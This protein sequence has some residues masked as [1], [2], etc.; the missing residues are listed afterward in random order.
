ME[1]TGEI[2]T[3]RRTD[4][5]T[6]SERIDAFLTEQKLTKK[7]VLRLRLTMEELLLRVREHSGEETACTLQMGRRIG[8]AYV[9]VDYR[10][11]AFDP[12]AEDDG[13]S[14]SA[15]LLTNMGLAPSW[16]YVRGVNRL[17]LRPP[18]RKSRSLL[19]LLCAIGLACV[20]GLAGRLLPE[21]WRA[22]A[23]QAALTPLFNAYLGVMSTF[24]GLV[25][26]L[27]IACG[28]CGVGSASTFEQTGKT[29]LGRFVAR[30]MLWG[31]LGT[32]FGLLLFPQ[33]FGAAAQGE[34]QLKPIISLLLGIFPTNP[35]SPFADGNSLQI[36]FLAAAAGM[37]LL[38]LGDRAAS[39]RGWLEQCNAV[40]L[41][42]MERVCRLIPL[43]VFVTLL[44]LFWGGVLGTLLNLWKPLATFLLAMLLLSAIKA[45]AGC[46]RLRVKPA[47]LLRKVLTTYPAALTTA[48]SA[49]VFGDTGDTCRDKLGVSPRLTMMALPIGN[50]ICVPAAAVSFA[51]VLLYLA[52]DAGITVDE[53]WLVQAA[54]LSG[55]VA[56]AMPPI[57]GAFL[58]CFGILLTQM[59]LP[60]EGLV[61]M[62]TL[63]VVIDAVCTATTNLYLQMEIAEQADALGMLDAE[64]LRS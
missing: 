47:V 53:S 58:T 23:T 4:I 20:F 10:G 62:A 59:N 52:Q 54:L 5:D 33:R 31:V 21:A 41:L 39:V 43:F 36:I 28:V 63:N 2:F 48:S 50:M 46:L 49:A 56:I 30:T 15:Q 37:A 61:V 29:V 44:R 45:A 1:K 22:S 12:T 42:I 64:I 13:A 35:V 11:E 51:I 34:S 14:W 9:E 55:V 24:A 32:A 25:I 6:I 8:G 27:S 16:S 26:F 17:L 40:V 19:H 38:A 60:M 7:D 3:L 57:P 18:G